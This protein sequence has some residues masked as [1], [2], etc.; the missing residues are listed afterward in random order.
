MRRYLPEIAAVLTAAV[1]ASAPM[2]ASAAEDLSSGLWYFERGHVQDAHDAG[3]TG[4]GVTVAVLDTQINPDVPA[5]RGAN[6]EVIEESYCLDESGDRLPAVS[7]DYEAAYHGTNV[8]A[9]IA[10]TGASASG[11][12]GAKGVA[13]GARVLYYAESI[14]A[15]TADDASNAECRDESGES[16]LAGSAQAMS[17]AIEAGADIISISQGGTPSALMGAQIARAHALGV[18]VVAGMA[19]DSG[20]AGWPAGA[21]GVVAVQAFDANGEIQKGAPVPGIEP[22]PNL[23]DDVIVA[24]PGIG[25]LVASSPESWEV[26][27]LGTGTSLATPITAGFLAVVKSKFPDATGNQ[28][29]QSLLHNTGGQVDGELDWGNDMGYGAISLTAMLQVDPSKYPDEN[30]ILSDGAN[31]LPSLADVQEARLAAEAQSPSPAP[32][33]E[34]QEPST[35]AGSWLPW[36]IGGGIIGLLVIAGVVILVV[37]VSRSS[38]RSQ[39]H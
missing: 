39:E 14:A 7:T 17:D 12:P 20:V 31:E 5:L 10:G 27:R 19:N 29:I 1:L 34:P 21:N 13:P 38:R 8:A 6:I 26:E 30:P 36:A 15:P 22:T 25:I 23:S 37:I 28:L 24:A 33:V 4:E 9:L 2:S 35:D 11:G 3:F 32:S 16:T 18:I